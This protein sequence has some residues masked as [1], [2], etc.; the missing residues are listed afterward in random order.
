MRASR[1]FCRLEKICAG[2]NFLMGARAL[3]ERFNCKKIFA[4]FLKTPAWMLAAKSISVLRFLYKKILRLKFFISA[5]CC[6]EREMFFHN[7]R[8]NFLFECEWI[9]TFFRNL[10]AAFRKIFY[11][12]TGREKAS[13][14][15]FETAFFYAYLESV[16]ALG[17]LKIGN[18]GGK[19]FYI[20]WQKFYRLVCVCYNQKTWAFEK[21]RR[22][23][24]YL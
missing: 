8:V 24:S 12:C 15:M 3:G 18:V 4:F 21:N 19:K 13:L 9:F 1:F 16:L 7:C 10:G 5:K 17:K 20:L 11:G 23:K 14:P 2:R 6:S 22:G